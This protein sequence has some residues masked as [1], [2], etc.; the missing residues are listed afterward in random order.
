MVENY[1]ERRNHLVQGLNSIKGFKC[2]LPHGAF[3]AFPNIK[4]TGLDDITISK[5]L[6]VQCGVQ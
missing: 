6:L 5:E 3:Y 4:D 1:Q 2:S